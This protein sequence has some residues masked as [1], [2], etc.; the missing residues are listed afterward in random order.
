M[1]KVFSRL[2]LQL[3]L[4][5]SIY[6]LTFAVPAVNI[7]SITVSAGACAQGQGTVTVYY[8]V[9]DSSGL[10]FGTG[11]TFR[12]ALSNDNFANQTLV[13]STRSGKAT[14]PYIDTIT[15]SLSVATGTYKLRLV[16]TAPSYNS[17]PHTSSITVNPLPVIT[18]AATNF[19]SY[20]C[21]S[22]VISEACKGGTL[23]ISVTPQPGMPYKFQWKS[24]YS[25]TLCFTRSLANGGPYFT[26]V[27]TP[28]LS[29]T[30]STDLYLCTVTDS[31]TGCYYNSSMFSLIFRNDPNITQQPNS[32]SACPGGTA[33]FTVSASGGTPSLNYQWQYN[34]GGTWGNVVNGT[35]LGSTYAGGT[36]SSLNVSGTS[37]TGTYQYRCLISA[38]GSGCNPLTSSTATLTVVTQPTT[39][40]PTLTSGSICT[41]GSSTISAT[42]S[43]GTGAY[44]YQ[45]QYYNGSTWNSVTSGSPPGASYSGATTSAM[46]ISGI[47][48]AGT[49][50][51][52]CYVTTTGVNCIGTGPSKDLIVT[53]GSSATSTASVSSIC[54]GGAFTDLANL[55]N[56]TLPILSYQW[57]YYNGSTWN[58]VSAGAPVGAVYSGNA[59]N[60][61]SVTGITAVGT[62]EYRCW[63]TQ[64]GACSS[65]TSSTSTVSVVADPSITTQPS[66]PAPVCDGG[67]VN[68][69]VVAAGGTP[70]LNY[71]WQ[72]NNGGT[73]ANVVNGTPTG[74]NYSG[75]NALTV[76]GISGAGTYQYRC[77][78][79]ASGSGCGTVSSNTVDVAVVS[80]PA[81][82]QNP[83]NF[84]ICRGGSGILRIVASGG[85]PSLTYQWKYNNGGSWQ[86]V[87]NGLPTS[88]VYSNATT[89]ALSVAGIDVVGSF[90]YQ[91]VV[92]ATGSGC[93]TVTSTTG[94]INVVQDPTISQQ[95]VNVT[96]CNLIGVGFK[97][98]ATGGTPSLTYQWE[99]SADGISS[100]NPINPT[101]YTGGTTDS[102]TITGIPPS[103]NFWRCSISSTGSGCD[104]VYSNVV[105]ATIVPIPSITTQPITPSPVCI[106]GSA[107]FSVTATGG[108]PSLN[109]Q[110]QYSIDTI[111]WSNVVNNTPSGA[112]YANQTTPSLIVNGISGAGN[113]F[114]RCVVSAT[115][116]GCTTRNSYAGK[117]TVV[118]DPSITTQPSNPAAVCVGGSATFSISATNGTP[119]LNY[120]WQYNNAGTWANVAN[121]LP[122]GSTYS[123]QTTNALTVSGINGAGNYQYR[124][125][126]SATG[127]GCD[128]INSNSGTLTVVADPSITIQPS[129]PAA[130]CAGGSATF[131]VSATNGTPSLNYQWQYNNAGTW[132]NVINNTPAGAIYSNQTTNA[133]SVNGI[134]NA[135]NYQYRCAVSATGS[136][137]DPINSSAGTLTVIADP[138]ITTQPVNPSAIC[139]G[140]S[141]VFNVTATN[142][143]PS[144]NYQ[145]QYNNGGTWANVANSTPS[146][147]TYSNQTSNTL[148][149]TGISVA[150]SYQYRCEVSATGNGCD[151][152]N[153][154][155][156]T[157][158]VVA[159]PSIVTQPINPATV[160]TGGTSNLSIA[161]AG[162][163]PFISYQWQ[164][165]FD[166]INWSNV[167]NNTP[168][169]AS[170]ANQTTSA[171]SINGISNAG[172]YLYRCAIS[173]TGS[174]CNPINS[175]S[176]TVTV[177]DQA[178]PSTPTINTDT[179]CAGGNITI[180][181]VPI[182]SGTGSLSYQWQYNTGGSWG[183][184]SNGQPGGSVYSGQSTNT[185]SVSSIFATGS[186]QWR[187]IITP[188]GSGCQAIISNPDS[189]A[190]IIDPVVSAPI[191]GSD[192]IC[193]QGSNVGTVTIS[194]GS[195][196]ASY[197][198]QYYNGS[199]W[200]NV[201]TGA[202]VGAVYSND[203]TSQLN[204][205]GITSLGF[206]L[207]RTTLTQSTSGCD[208]IGLADSFKV[209]NGPS[210]SAPAFASICSGGASTA[211]VTASGGGGNNFFQWQYFNGNQWVNVSNNS[212]TGA[213]Y[214][215]QT[216]SSIT[217]SG[218]INS[219]NYQY[220]CFLTQSGSSCSATSPIANLVVADALGFSQ[221][222]TDTTVCVGF[223]SI[224]FTSNVVGGTPSVSY[225]WQYNNAGNWSPVIN[226][227]PSG[228][229]YTGQTSN[230]L[231][232]AGISSGNNQ[233]QCLISAS[234]NACTSNTSQLA[235]LYVLPDPIIT[236]SPISPS[237]I[238][239]GGSVNFNLAASGGVNGLSYQWQF[240][241]GGNWQSVTDG[242]PK[243]AHYTGA[244]SSNLSITTID[245]AGIF[246]YRC[247]V[248]STGN[249]CGSAISSTVN[250]VVNLSPYYTTQPTSPAPVCS[251]LNTVADLNVVV[252]SGNLS[253][254]YQ[255]QYL[256]S[257]GQW[258]S[259][260]NG[261]PNNVVYTGADSANLR[262]VGLTN[263]LITPDTLRFR[264][265]ISSSGSSCNPAVSNI[266]Y[267]VV[268]SG[269]S[270]SQP[271]EDQTICVGGTATVTSNVIGGNQPY[272]YDWKYYNGSS[273]VSLGANVPT[274]FTYP[275][276]SNSSATLSAVSANNVN[277]GVY[278]YIC[279]VSSQGTG[280]NSIQ[281]DTIEILV[282][283]DPAVDPTS[284]PPAICP[285][286]LVTINVNLNT[287]TPGVTYLWLHYNGTSY[288]TVVNGINNGITYNGAN[289]NILLINTSEI[290]DTGAYIYKHVVSANWSGCATTVANNTLNIL[291]EPFLS[292][293]N[294]PVSPAKICDGGEIQLSTS[295]TGGTFGPTYAWE[296]AIDTLLQSQVMGNGTSY[297][298]QSPGFWRCKV[299]YDTSS[300]CNSANTE[301]VDLLVNND[302]SISLIVSPS[303]VCIG[304]TIT[305]TRANSGGVGN[306]L[307]SIE[308]SSDNITWNSTSYSGPIFYPTDTVPVIY[309]RGIFN[310]G[311]TSNQNC[312]VDTSAVVSFN[313]YSSP[314]KAI[315]TSINASEIC[316]GSANVEIDILNPKSN[317]QYKW[318]ISPDE[319]IALW[320]NNSKSAITFSSGASYTLQI[321]SNIDGVS[322]FDTTKSTFVV[323]QSSA[324]QNVSIVLT[325]PGNNLFCSNT[326]Y[327]SYQ[328]GYD[329]QSNGQS[330]TISG[331][332]TPFYNTQ[333]TFEPNYKAYWLKVCSG[334][335][336]CTKV[337]YNERNY[338]GFAQQGFS[339]FTLF[340][341]PTNDYIHI[342]DI[343]RMVD[344]IQLYTQEGKKLREIKIGDSDDSYMLDMR[345]YAAGMYYIQGYLGNRQVSRAKIILVK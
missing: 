107:N 44:S 230:Q 345:D 206:F 341:N 254:Q 34:N 335:G 263:T 250:V 157:L 333:G 284:N 208:A 299:V 167:A 187:C 4:L 48:S 334:D 150:G 86:N 198:W 186:K 340:P 325:Q 131:S 93:G 270:L 304:D 203:T 40:T 130:V 261:V 98:I 47:S 114:Y 327:S 220:R 83:T 165:S 219:G 182:S 102:L 266:A 273:F 192:T 342:S 281:S 338:L 68:F 183:N 296:L 30:D 255:W 43:G 269:I 239:L 52:R 309:Y 222:P 207:Y 95:P 277:S 89:N 14:S 146:G 128:A 343:D 339:T 61:L 125:A 143:T 176:A 212:P 293:L 134:S 155:L 322:C 42:A 142:G 55:V 236:V 313:S 58:N 92:S 319:P 235:S 324:P 11:S 241:N 282:V 301:W 46:T 196:N 132:S 328:W 120:Q 256:N 321:V 62:Y 234:G 113:Y 314:D 231:Q 280:C 162:G 105:T 112:I 329:L 318:S 49:Y 15:A 305:I 153:S 56:G 252:N 59:T 251:G 124:C 180:V 163:T 295:L 326:G 190:V 103:A 233:Y 172:T 76:S 67:S 78:V 272:T 164:Y 79:S 80:D 274:G 310:S 88:A 154:N 73:F 137:C 174:G 10:D 23:A 21:S 275:G 140:G 195:G 96:A 200:N 311:F 19:G 224:K 179:I 227:V 54:V 169:G 262:M 306:D 290:A 201:L 45:W 278:K 249:G 69:S 81:I 267:V 199:T 211:N 139:A 53:S 320:D 246:Q 218:I 312:D 20:S 204:I 63:I 292:S 100:W 122:L 244:N 205:N 12:I 2:F 166:G 65:V 51:Y 232:V 31:I 101:Y 129:N 126:V 94:V 8:T 118:S 152:V 158:T 133:L 337:Y 188:S 71:Q 253:V 36:A 60:N 243:D 148:S 297:N 258:Q 291:Q 138:S 7:T 257:N 194:G 248:T 75:T 85:T 271:I 287:N 35:P 294:F 332:S 115:G 147:A 238:C 264:C 99:W 3:I 303:Y 216:N 39:T 135:G 286:G 6:S 229:L 189:V 298:A 302:P 136:G 144:L 259:V 221:Q 5:L 215:G 315:L 213:T 9:T 109:Y 285:G 72:Y 185:L 106:G 245:T 336:C 13:G 32:V 37:S 57:Q 197:R 330:N 289:S 170:Y 177:V 151:L 209:V 242:L 344:K 110:W 127:S 217:V 64:S 90:Q 77:N 191:F 237:A 317:Y 171:I 117:L 29:V 28:T 84:T 26:N 27:T 87:V 265:V 160:C 121:G 145:W 116:N 223:S 316:V 66:N 307:F 225:Q 111:T 184:V 308:N 123:N 202:P 17:Q 276:L 178:L 16:V 97:V 159:D 22:G 33:N 149:V 74:A 70:T 18:P 226:G 288:D 331:A 41:G 119:S 283:P 300:G 91:C 82:S 279:F 210:L 50:S 175:N 260:I 38:S 25:S 156:A 173:A 228:A 104:V 168:A 323:N 240:N 268:K 141:A 193:V 108:T 1:N 24:T 214:A 161:A 181:E 247:I